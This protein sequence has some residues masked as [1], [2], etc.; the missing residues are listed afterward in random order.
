MKEFFTGIKKGQKL[1]G[2]TISSI[3]NSLLLSIVYLLGVGLTAFSAKIF[4]KH[5]LDL[6]IEKT[7]ETYWEELNLSRE[8]MEDYHRQF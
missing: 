2:E 4:R 7:R 3:I 1:F 5:F 8:N 6:N